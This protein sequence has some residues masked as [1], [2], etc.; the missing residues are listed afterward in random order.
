MYN[1]GVKRG[2][3]HPRHKAVLVLPNV[4][5]RRLPPHLLQCTG[6][7]IILVMTVH[8]EVTLTM[9]NTLHDE[10]QWRPMQL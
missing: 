1:N 9:D 3:C 8:M 7:W 6:R 10:R 4:G 5:G 2:Q